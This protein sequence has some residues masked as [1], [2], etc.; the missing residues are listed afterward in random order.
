VPRL[1]IRE[2]STGAVGIEAT[3]AHAANDPSREST[4]LVPAREQKSAAVEKPNGSELEELGFE[5][6]ELGFE[7]STRLDSGTDRRYAHAL[8]LL[9]EY[10]HW[11][12]AVVTEAADPVIVGIAVRRVGYKELGIA[13]AA[14]DPVA[15]LKIIDKHGSR[16]SATLH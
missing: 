7:A 16:D 14:Y 10:P 9:A 3:S 6:E 2:K 8:A 4:P 15:L 5:L 11:R 1:A 13:S 12:I